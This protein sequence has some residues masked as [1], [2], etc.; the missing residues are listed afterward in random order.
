M[1]SP[2]DWPMLPKCPRNSR[3]QWQ[4]RCRWDVLERP[5]VAWKVAHLAIPPWYACHIY[6][7]SY[8]PDCSTDNHW[9]HHL[10]EPYTSINDQIYSHS[11]LP[12]LISTLTHIY[13]HSYL[14]SHSSLPSLI[15]TLTHISIPTPL[16]PHSSPCPHTRSIND[17]LPRRTDSWDGGQ[18][19][20]DP[21]SRGKTNPVPL[22]LPWY[23]HP[24][25]VDKEQIR[26]ENVDISLMMCSNQDQWMGRTWMM[27]LFKQG[28][29]EI[30]V[31][32]CMFEVHVV[33]L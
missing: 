33:I 21:I 26:L 4:R 3:E 28:R 18:A 13:P 15:S 22:L 2:K 16:Y 6:S 5:M 7:H 8:L 29:K 12:L 24:N 32:E 14:Y 27:L 11:F 30:D 20:H 19:H 31:F 25:M 23:W 17:I 9:M 10:I 1:W